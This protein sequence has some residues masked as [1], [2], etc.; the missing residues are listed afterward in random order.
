MTTACIT[1]LTAAYKL[2]VNHLLF[3]HAGSGQQQQPERAHVLRL[4]LCH[5]AGADPSAPGPSGS[6]LSTLPQDAQWS[7]AGQGEC[8]TLASC[9]MMES[10]GHGHALRPHKRA[11]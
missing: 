2:F 8:H 1:L 5:W 9:T 7:V 10:P 11:V 4:C 3:L 6:T